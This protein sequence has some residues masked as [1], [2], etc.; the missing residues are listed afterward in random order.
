MEMNGNY[1][2]SATRLRSFHDAVPAFRS[3]AGNPRDYLEQCLATIEAREPVVQAWVTMNVEDARKAADASAQ[4]YKS[5]APLS[6]I[7]GMPIGIKDLIQT[8][9]MPT[10]MGSPIFKGARTGNDSAVVRALR[11][12]GAIVLGKTVTTEFGMSH[13]G[14]TANPFD[15]RRTPGGSSSGSAAAVGAGMVPV[16]IGSQLLGSILRPAGYCANIAIKPTLGAIHRGERMGNSQGHVGVHAGSMI[17]LWNTTYEVAARAGGDP[18]YPGLYGAAEVPP[19]RKPRRLIVMETE[20]WHQVEPPTMEAFEKI[21]H[22]LRQ[23][24]VEVLRRGDH[25]LVEMFEQS[26]ADNMAMCRDVIGFEGRWNYENLFDRAP[27]LL[28]ESILQRLKRWRTLTREQYRV[29]LLKRQ[30]ARNRH[31]ALAHVGDAL[32]GLSSNGP[33]AF[34]G[35]ET[36]SGQAI[37]HT[38]GTP[39]MA[40]PS[41][42]L[43][44][45]AVVVPLLSVHQMPLGV[46]VVGQPHSDEA[47][48]GIARWL[49][50]KLPVALV[51]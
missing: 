32:I 6:S 45:P 4:R 9:D 18:G 14:P 1:D 39:A 12:A 20:A 13:P 24:G 2:A 36:G 42:T 47:T 7:D 33:A 19:A 17:D 28:S 11:E 51:R 46:Q 23:Q 21:L 50:E 35:D 22:S 29:A 37:T 34:F 26:I 3:G 40:A 30:E 49:L 5:G 38:T 48:V 25:E 31:A 15:P 43:G 27:D 44:A 10:E 8:R 41:S 16:C